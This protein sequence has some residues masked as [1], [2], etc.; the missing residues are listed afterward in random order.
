M[1]IPHYR[2]EAHFPSTINTEEG[3]FG[4]RLTPQP[5]LFL[6]EGGVVNILVN[7]MNLNTK[8]PSLA[9]RKK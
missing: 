9:P 6:W 7:L 4:K 5:H 3:E 2:K 8:V 1:A